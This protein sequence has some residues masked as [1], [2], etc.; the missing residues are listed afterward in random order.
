MTIGCQIQFAQTVDDFGSNL[1]TAQYMK[2]T[3]IRKITRPNDF[4]EAYYNVDRIHIGVNN[5]V[6]YAPRGGGEIVLYEPSDLVV[7]D[8]CYLRYVAGFND[9]WFGFA[10]G[11]DGYTARSKGDFQSQ[12]KQD[13]KVTDADLFVLD[14]GSEQVDQQGRLHAYMS[15][16]AAGDGVVLRKTMG[17]M[18]TKVNK[19]PEEASVSAY[20]NPFDDQINITT[21]GWAQGERVIVNVFNVQ[22]QKVAELYNGTVQNSQL[23][24]QSDFNGEGGIYFLEV[25]SETKRTVV[26]VIKN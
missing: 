7:N 3:E 26:R 6:S 17:W 12:F 9:A 24:L 11:A 20:P 4:S 25:T 15:V 16:F 23:Q 13:D 21:K 1:T 2:G 14:L 10:I 5:Q 18:P 22:G 19:L 8:A